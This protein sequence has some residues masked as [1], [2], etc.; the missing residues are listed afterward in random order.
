MK[1]KSLKII[2]V[3]VAAVAFLCA[4]TSRADKQV[5]AGFALPVHV[6]AVVDESD[7]VNHPGPTVT[8]SGEIKLGGLNARVIFSN[9]AKGTHTAVVVSQFDVTLLAEG[10]SIVIP[11]QPVQGGVGGNPHIY[12]QFHDGQGGDLSDEFYLGRCV[13]GLNITADLLQEAVARANVHA[14]GCSNRKG[15]FITLDGDIVLGGLHAR[16]I[17]RN[18]LKGTH[19][20]EDSRDVAIVLEGSKIVLPKQPVKGGVGG[21]PIISLQFL[22][23]N[24]DPIG[25]PV[26]LGRCVQL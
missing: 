20:A 24:G 17:F 18:N 19:T 2:Q 11:K 4:S 3:G 26:V 12:L 15:P 21:N 25:E 10:G 22:H 23:G 8:M 1:S 5:T 6:N 13:Q 14:E 16:F 9:N 7:C